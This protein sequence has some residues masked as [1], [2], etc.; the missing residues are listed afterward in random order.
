MTGPVGLD[1]V[2]PDAADTGRLAAAGLGRRHV[3]T[4]VALMPQVSL[5]LPLAVDAAL[6]LLSFVYCAEKHDHG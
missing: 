4:P 1:R 2:G 5:A 6:Q 3:P